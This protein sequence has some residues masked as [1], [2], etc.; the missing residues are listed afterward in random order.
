MN[1]APPEGTDPAQGTFTSRISLGIKK[2]ISVAKRRWLSRA[3]VFLALAFLLYF[4][5]RNAPLAEIWETLRSLQLWQIA[6][7]IGLNILI[8]ILVTARWW[9]IV[10]AEN[11]NIR[12]YPLVG[13]RLSVFGISYFTLGPQIGGEP[14][15]VLYL[16]RNYGLTYTRAAATVVMDKL[17]EFLANFFLLEFGLTALFQAG[18]FSTSVGPPRLLLVGLA[19]IVMWPLVH[20]IF[21]FNR[22]YP[23]SALMRILSF[24]RQD[25]KFVRFLR[26][27]EHLAGQFCQ[28]HPRTFFAA[29]MV[30]I[31]ASAGTVSEYALITSFLKIGL[32]FWQTAAAWTA[33]WLSFLVP[34]PGGLGALEAS[35]VFALGFFGVPAA[36]AISVTLM[37]RCRDLFFGG[38]GLLLA[39]DAARKV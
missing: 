13:V 38:L 35:Q 36:S 18:I 24:L 37:M 30:S 34:L 4:A 11:R 22:L 27:C 26:A 28:R 17:L 21:L 31:F 10:H 32:P 19:V 16:Q 23:L 20:L 3:V 33:G 2:W 5:F 9:F 8:Y 29:I 1:S 14:L 15:Q 7:L 6:L 25:G 39:G 12:Y